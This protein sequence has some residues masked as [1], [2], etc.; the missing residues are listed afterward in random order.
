MENYEQ[1]RYDS[2]VYD[3]LREAELQAASTTERCTHE[4]VMAKARAL[5]NNAEEW[6]RT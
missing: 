3:K 6:N 2:L 1:S 5:L 4:E